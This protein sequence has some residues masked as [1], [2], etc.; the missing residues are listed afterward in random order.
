MQ[1]SKGTCQE[2]LSTIPLNAELIQV[3][4]S[5]ENRR[6]RMARTTIRRHTPGPS[7]SASEKESV[8]Y[9][10]QCPATISDP[11]HTLPSVRVALLPHETY[12]GI[13]CSLLST[14]V[15]V[16]YSNVYNA[17]LV[18]HKRSFLE[19][20][21]AGTV[22]PHVI[23]GVCAWASKCDLAFRIWFTQLITFMQLLPQR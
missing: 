9:A 22:R 20:L 1:E 2:K 10:V 4:C 15:E 3:R 19:A 7:I 12:L 13:P 17:S 6:F 23:L 11:N 14:L 5:G 21:S 16:Y 18:L 8:P